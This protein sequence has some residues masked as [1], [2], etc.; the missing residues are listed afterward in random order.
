MTAADD[1]GLLGGPRRDG[2]LPKLVVVGIAWAAIGVV[3][4]ITAVLMRSLGIAVFGLLCV[5]AGGGLWFGQR[6]RE[7][8]AH[9]EEML[10]SGPI[11]FDPDPGA[12]DDVVHGEPDDDR[13]ATR[14]MS[15]GSDDA[16]DSDDSRDR[17]DSRGSDDI[18]DAEY[19]E[20]IDYEPSPSDQ[21]DGTG[22]DDDE[23]AYRRRREDEWAREAREH[24]AARRGGEVIE[25]DEDEPA[26]DGS[27]DDGSGDRDPADDED[28]Q[29]GRDGDRSGTRR[30]G[31]PGEADR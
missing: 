31:S 7:R 3:A 14:V 20:Y 27:G 17:G 25:A 18:V 24:E 12:D 15:T 22:Y 2:P 23:M 19:D 21:D 10:S 5:L 13:H 1:R 30:D 29:D 11:E 16:D 8:L 28:R 9:D 6:T 4:L 26:D